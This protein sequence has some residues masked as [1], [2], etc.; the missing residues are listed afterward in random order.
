[1]NWT[2]E[3]IFLKMG[4]F[5]AKM[6]EYAC[7]K[8]LFCPSVGILRQEIAILRI[9]V[10]MSTIIG[11]VGG[12]GIGFLLQQNINLLNYRAASAQMFAIAIVVASMDYV[13]SVLREKYV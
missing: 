13:S 5:S 4:K 3:V 7:I 1:M 12:G 8:P 9:A 11:F 10:R 2:V 6:G